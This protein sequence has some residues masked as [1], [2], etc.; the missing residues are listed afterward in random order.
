MQYLN[1][2]LSDPPAFC[3]RTWGY[4]KT[5]HLA[6]SPWL[7][8]FYSRLMFYS[9]RWGQLQTCTLTQS[10]MSKPWLHPK[11][12]VII[13]VHKCTHWCHVYL[14]KDSLVPGGKAFLDGELWGP[15]YSKA[16]T[17]H[18]PGHM[19]LF[20]GLPSYAEFICRVSQSDQ[21][22]S[23]ALEVHNT[24]KKFLLSRSKGGTNYSGNEPTPTVHTR[25]VL[26]GCIV[27]NS[28]HEAEQSG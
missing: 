16:G 7:I 9:A 27:Q 14:Q 3:L 21:V 10:H 25:A 1:L 13:P 19:P 20:L 15:R 23:R 4:Y 11:R 8:T 12:L 5:W 26:Y 22:Q 24:R 17:Q 18:S 2:K 28:R 6:Q